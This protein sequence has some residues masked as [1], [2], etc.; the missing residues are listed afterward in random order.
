MLVLVDT[1][2]G[3]ASLMLPIHSASR[4]QSASGRLVPGRA[5]DTDRL[6]R[7]ACRRNHDAVALRRHDVQQLLAQLLALRSDVEQAQVPAGQYLP[8]LWVRV[9]GLGVPLL[10]RRELLLVQ[11]LGE[12]RGGGEESRAAWWAARGRDWKRVRRWPL[13][14]SARR[15]EPSITTTGM[16]CRT[17]NSTSLREMAPPFASTATHGSFDVSTSASVK[18]VESNPPLI[19]QARARS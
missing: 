17:A 15:P 5:D 14:W 11:R 2:S 19:A 10:G 8:D 16:P 12:L 13:A 3:T 1:D 9:Q 18:M 4:F 7:P 6:G